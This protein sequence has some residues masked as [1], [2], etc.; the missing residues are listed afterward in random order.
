V[1]LDIVKRPAI[2]GT[3]VGV[4]VIALIWWFAWMSPEGSKLTSVNHQAQTAQIEISQ[5]NTTV[6]S[7]KAQSA[8]L[9]QILPYL[10]HFEVAIPNLPESGILTE[11]LFQLSR[12]TGVFIS[13]LN[14]AQVIAGTTSTGYS[15]IPVSIVLSGSRNGILNFI[16]DIY[17]MPRLVTLQAVTLTPGGANPDVNKS[18]NATGANA[19][20]TGTA[21]TT[22]I[23]PSPA[24][25]G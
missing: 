23:P 25:A 15:T 12:Q 7:L 9:Q 5:L 3:I 24:P 2:Y 14:D 11:Q 17:K 4:L 16:A 8:D 6:A 1:N 21:Y 19:S 22:F 18:S 10:A 20:I 13:N